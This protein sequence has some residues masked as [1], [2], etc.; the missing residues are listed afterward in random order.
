[1]KERNIMEFTITLGKGSDEWPGR[2]LAN[3]DRSGGK[4][5]SGGIYDKLFRFE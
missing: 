3:F 4:T 5:R 2:I 1:M